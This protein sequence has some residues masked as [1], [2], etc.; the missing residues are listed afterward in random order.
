MTDLECELLAACKAQHEAI[1]ILFSM[2][3]AKDPVTAPDRFMPS[4]SGFPWQAMLAGYVA[5]AR[6]TTASVRAPAR[7]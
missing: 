3:I 6:A 5:I 1:D 2:L 4:K 7:D